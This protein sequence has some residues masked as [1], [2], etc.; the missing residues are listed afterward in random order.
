MRPHRVRHDWTIELKHKSYPFFYEFV[1]ILKYN[2]TAFLITQCSDFFI[3]FKIIT[4]DAKSSGSLFT[5]AKSNLR[6]KVLGEVEM[7]SF[8]ALPGKGKHSGLMPS[9]LCAHLL[10]EDRSFTVIVQRGV[11]SSWASFC[12]GGGKLSRTQHRQPSDPTALGSLCLWAVC[13]C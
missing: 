7:N 1:C 5:S 10:G 11:I 2:T 4:S 13:H 8:I 9:K 3:H 6:D 12:W